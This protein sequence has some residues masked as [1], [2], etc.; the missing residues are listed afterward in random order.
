[1]TVRL[2]NIGIL[3]QAEFSLGD[4]TI[5]C[6][7]NNTGKTYAACALYGFLSSWRNFLRFPISNAHIQQARTELVKIDLAQATDDMLTEAC[8]KY[9]EQ[10]HKIFAAPEGTFQDSE[11]HFE[12]DEI[13]IEHKKFNSILTSLQNP[14]FIFSKSEGSKEAILAARTEKEQEREIDIDSVKSAI[15]FIIIEDIFSGS[16]PRPFIASA[17]RTGISTFRKELNFARSRL[18]DEMWHANRKID[19][20]ELRYPFPIRDDAEF[21]GRFEDSAKI[22]S[23]I[24]KE[25]PE[26][27]ED[28]ADIVGGK[29]VITQNDQLYYVP[30]D[31]R[32]KLTMVESSSSVRSLLDI[33]FYLRHEAEKGDLLMIDEPELS[34]HPENQRRIT[35]LFARLANLGVKVFITTHSDYIVK[36]LNTLIMLNHDKP[37]LKRV[38]EENGYQDSELISVDQVKVYIAEKA[39]LP[40]EEGQKRRRRGHTLV[41]AKIHPEL[42]IGVSSFDKTIDDMNRIQDDIVWG[43]E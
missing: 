18:L 34:L 11:F 15:D 41:P 13:D 5:I 2:K 28:F 24:A 35:R 38:A 6:G 29:Y 32:H 31:T 12:T 37:H 21:I 4:L 30:K 1:M 26:I 36:E 3:K 19:L 42:G 40:L 22:K 17:E 8:K 16:F 25:H 9:T 10:L 23:F 39:L 33:S 20:W 14:A 43:E 7:E 27:L